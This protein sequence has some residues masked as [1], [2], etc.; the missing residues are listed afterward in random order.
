ME[1]IGR[2]EKK[3]SEDEMAGL[4]VA[5]G[6]HEFEQLKVGDGPREAP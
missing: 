6:G 2:S 4:S 1:K 5:I 3:D